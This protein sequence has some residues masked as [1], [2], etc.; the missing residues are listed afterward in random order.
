MKLNYLAPAAGPGRSALVADRARRRPPPRPRSRGRAAA[1]RGLRLLVPAQPRPLGQPAAVGQVA[2][3]RSTC[4]RPSQALGGPAPGARS[5]ATCPTGRPGTTGSCPAST[6]ALGWAWPAGRRRLA[7]ALACSPASGARRDPLAAG[8]R[9][10]GPGRG[11]GLG[12]QPRI[13]R[14]ARGHAARLR[15]RA[16]LPGAG[17]GPRPGAAAG[18]DRRREARCPRRRSARHCCWRC[19]PSPTP[20]GRPWHSGY[21]AGAVAVGGVAVAVAAPGRVLAPRPGH[22]PRALAAAARRAL[23]GRGRRR[24]GQSSGVT[25]TTATRDPTFA[26]AGLNDAFDWARELRGARIAT[27]ATRQ[28]PLCGYRPLQ[29]GPLRRQSSGRTAA[30]S[31]PA[32]CRQWRRADHDGRL[33]LRGREPRPG[34]AR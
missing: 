9:R 12:R 3:G 15:V 17:A 23:R 25:S 19:S 29:R 6:R 21:V 2:S 10:R 20:P 31:A 11:A 26:A 13:G 28:Y 1:A 18:G 30:S 4:R 14:R 24:L 8:A 7:L 5:S 34:R 16:A 32:S 22:R 33:R 27:T